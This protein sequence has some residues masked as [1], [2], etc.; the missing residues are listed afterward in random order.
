MVSAFAPIVESDSISRPGAREPAV[1]DKLFQRGTLDLKF[2]LSRKRPRKSRWMHQPKP[3]QFVEYS[4]FVTLRPT[5]KTF[6]NKTVL[7]TG[8][9]LWH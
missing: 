4:A 3:I 5:M 7:I 8:R 6:E 2:I 9:R 1:R